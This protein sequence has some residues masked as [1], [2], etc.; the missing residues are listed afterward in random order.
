MAYQDRSYYSSNAG[1]S[2]NENFTGAVKILI[3]A[4][5]V[6]FVLVNLFRNFPWF[7]V[8]GLVP[9]SVISRLM[10]WQLITY[11]FLHAGL[12]HL[13]LNLLMLWM[14]GSVLEKTW[15]KY[16]FLIYYFFTGIG[17]GVCS[18]IFGYNSFSPVVGASGSIFGLLVAYAIMFPEAIILLFFIFPMKM[19][20][21]AI[22]LAGI[23]LLGALSNPG[24]GIAYIAHLGG[25][26]F[27]YLYFK[28]GWIRDRL[29]RLSWKELKKS[30]TKK[31]IMK[32]SLQEDWTSTEV[33]RILDKISQSGI[34]SL[35]L[36][37]KNFLAKKAKNN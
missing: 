24:N 11:L 32:S 26:L 19:K 3:A 1:F 18:C 7:A 12:W 16:K 8:F 4:N 17:A 37:E 29:S 31:K 36:K 9:T 25:G 14:F 10:F 22:V 2:R 6:L 5:I 34:D 13:V 15:G 20:Y 21:A 23:N 30:F 28:S 35:S 33:D 27:G